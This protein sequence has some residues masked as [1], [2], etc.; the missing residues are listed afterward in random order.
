M[1]GGFAS[2]IGFA[3]ETTFDTRAVPTR[4]YEFLNEG[5]KVNLE[6]LES[7]GLRAGRGTGPTRWALGKGDVA[8]PV[9]FEA[10]PQGF[11]LLLKHAIGPN[12]T[13]GTGPFTHTFA[14]ANIDALSLTTQIGKPDETGT[15]RPFDYTGCV[16]TGWSLDADISAFLKMTL[17]LYATNED[18]SQSLATASYPATITPFT[19]VQGTVTVAGS[20]Q[21]VKKIS[22]GADNARATGRHQIRA[23]TPGRPKKAVQTGRKNIT[24]SFA[25]DFTDLTLYNR[26]KNGTEAALVLAFTSGANSL[27]ITANIRTDGDTPNVTGP[28]LLEQPISFKCLSST[29]D[30]AAF[31]AVLVNGDAAP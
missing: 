22:I 4:F 1:S 6:R 29:S 3:E 20:A 14:S 21:D 9:V 17:D 31:T 24:G 26:F 5:L 13:T 15:V 10:A 2:Q 18:T 19:Y 16:V 28:D 7:M 23:T 27:T 11:G 30:A 25:A 12:V 8:G